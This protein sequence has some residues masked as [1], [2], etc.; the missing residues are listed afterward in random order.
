VTTT[1][2]SI[3]QVAAALD[4]AT[5][6]LTASEQRLAIAVYRGLAEGEPVET[7]QLASVTGLPVETVADTL[8]SWP[9]V[10]YDSGG[11][12][13]GFWGL[14]LPKMPHRFDVDGRTLYTWCAWD[15]LFIAPVLDRT[16]TVTTRCPVTRETITLSAAPEGPRDVSPSEAVMSFLR[17]D[18]PW[19]DDVIE[20]FCHF[21]LLFS[22]E[23]AGRQWVAR[24]PGTFLLSLDEAFELARSHLR[25]LGASTTPSGSQSAQRVTVTGKPTSLGL[26]FMGKP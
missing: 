11:R 23:D 15:P 19:A 17:P 4:L 7:A 1:R 26:G 2:P 25:R 8:R 21:I 5:P 24:H 12:V 18:D 13:I 22:S 20:R 6:R 9:G 10:F 14:A 3:H 16:A